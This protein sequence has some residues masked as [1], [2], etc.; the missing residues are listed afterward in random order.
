M[1]LNYL[2]IIEQTDTGYSAYVPDLP[3]C[4][5]AGSSKK[6]IEA[7]IQEAILL[8]LEGMQADRMD[9]PLPHTQA[10]RTSVARV[11]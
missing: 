6:E 2:V 9:I 1:E 4:I 5:T 11:V 3:G 7:N 10:F 8:H